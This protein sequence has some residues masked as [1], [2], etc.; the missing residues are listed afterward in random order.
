MNPTIQNIGISI[1]MLILRFKLFAM[2]MVHDA[3]RPHA[4]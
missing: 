2:E 1:Y 4:I 3:W